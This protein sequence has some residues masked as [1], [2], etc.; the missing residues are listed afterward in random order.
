MDKIAV[1]PKETAQLIAAGEVVERPA[2]VV[3]ELVENAIDAGASAVT[4]DISD[5]G[6]TSIRVQDNG[7]GMSEADARACF[8]RHATSKVR[9]AEDIYR[10]QTLG[11]RGEA[12]ASI[13]AVARVRLVTKRAEDETGTLV[14]MEGGTLAEQAPFGCPD[15]TVITVSDLFY[16][17]PARKKFLKSVRSET[18]AILA[19]ADRLALSHPEI[20][21]RVISQG[22]EE[23]FTP[24]DGVLRNAVHAVLGAKVAEALLPVEY[25]VNGVSITG[26]ITKPL[27]ARGNRNMQYFFIND[28]TVQSKTLYATL[29][30][31]YKGS[32]M[33]GKFPGCIL[34]IAVDPAR[35]DVNVHPTK[36]VVKFSDE[37]EIFNYMLRAVH[38]ALRGEGQQFTARPDTRPAQEPGKS[39]IRPA[40]KRDLS[41]F[42]EQEAVQ[43]AMS[44]PTGPPRPAAGA[45]AFSGQSA[46]SRTG[47]A[48]RDS[49]APV[50]LYGG[51]PAPPKYDAV[52]TLADSGGAI[53]VGVMP[54]AFKPSPAAPSSLPTFRIEPPAPA[55]EPEPVPA[56]A[57]PEPAEPV[58]YIGEVLRT[59]LIA[60]RGDEVYFVDKHAAHERILYDQLAQAGDTP[61]S[62]PLLL[63]RT[64]LLGKREK[65]ALLEN[66]ESLERC[67]FEIGDLGG[68]TLTVR[69]VPHVLDDDDVE[70]A[71]AEIADELL[72]GKGGAEL[73]KLDSIRAVTA[74]KAAVKAGQKNDPRENEALLEQLFS[75]PDLKYCPHGRPLIY[76]L[77]KRDFEKFFKR[78]V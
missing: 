34:H 51:V 31:A 75:R 69:A 14:R 55:A 73:S 52:S 61:V 49:A 54:P 13:A 35:I 41:A 24:G 28:R 63:S 78:I 11:F 26:Y 42:F 43:P 74:C 25:K 57:E 38:E 21:F 70:T 23:L 37:N 7:S 17:T 16:N 39:T 18:S 56:S 46:F 4:V 3:K 76:T 27:F 60:Q 9:R 53:P 1:L 36:S 8:L 64:L 58:L 32:I 48:C 44:A 50:N 68:G 71:L 19:L 5:G 59:Y 30:A 6:T 10:V 20:S 72:A 66:A 29:D 2:S 22:R 33:A 77:T 45:S 67:G 15:G 62:Q 40:P 65:S 12:L 47:T